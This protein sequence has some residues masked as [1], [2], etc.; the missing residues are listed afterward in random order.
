MTNLN[1]NKGFEAMIPK[2]KPKEE[3]IFRNQIKFKIF[4]RTISFSLELK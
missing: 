1:I 2:Q 3:V 4:K